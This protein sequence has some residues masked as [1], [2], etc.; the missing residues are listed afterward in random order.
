MN[1]NVRN[2]GMQNNTMLNSFQNRRTNNIPFQNNALIA[3]NP[4]MRQYASNYSVQDQQQLQS[5]EMERMRIQRVGQQMTKMKQMQKLKQIEKYND[6]EKYVDKDKFKDSIIEPIKLTKPKNPTELVKKSDQVKKDEYDNETYIKK[7]FWDSR[8]NNP[9]KSALVGVIDR[10]NLDENYYKKNVANKNDLIIHTTTDKEK[11]T[12]DDEFEEFNI[13]L[14]KHD[15]DLGEIYS[16]SNKGDNLKKFKYNNT[17]KFRI[18][19]DPADFKKLK[20]DKIEYYK[21]EQMKLEKDKKLVED[22]VESEMR[23]GLLNDDE[24]KTILENQEQ[25][26]SAFNKKM[27]TE[28]GDDI[29]E[30]V[31]KKRK[32]KID[33]VKLNYD[34][35][36][37]D[38]NDEI[39]SEDE[40]VESKSKS[41]KSKNS[42]KNTTSSSNCDD[43]D[44]EALRNRQKTTKL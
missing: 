26:E 2:N 6:I 39:S 34:E 5:T 41:K 20:K 10:L 8:T 40:K 27:A 15:K 4:N 28:Y 11:E 37:K 7:N 12:L 22:L 3:N 1:N 35:Y 23:S 24:V 44:D 25:T 16:I 42:N 9:Y 43:S 30:F 21:N 29:S 32:S 19:Y 38:Q 14:K 13:F 31:D 36:D 17:K 18:K 33:V